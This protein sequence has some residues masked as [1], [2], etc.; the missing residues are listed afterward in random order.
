MLIGCPNILES[1]GHYFVAIQSS[2]NDEGHMLLIRDR[3]GDL[4]ISP[5]GIHEA[6]QLVP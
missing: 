5:I 1:E 2:I 6:E 3:H 4:V